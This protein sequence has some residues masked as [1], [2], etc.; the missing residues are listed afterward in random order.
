M[1]LGPS[2]VSHL[3]LT[4]QGLAPACLGRY[5]LPGLTVLKAGTPIKTV[6]PTSGSYDRRLSACTLGKDVFMDK[7]P[8]HPMKFTLNLVIPFIHMA[9]S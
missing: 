5:I 6:P 7:S 4:D 8:S 3:L 1:P 9:L 2:T